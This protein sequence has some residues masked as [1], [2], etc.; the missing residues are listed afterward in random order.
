MFMPDDVYLTNKTARALYGAVRGLPIYDY[1]SHLSAQDM[2]DD[3]RYDNIGRL[4][5]ERRAGG[6]DHGESL[7]AR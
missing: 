1:H 7:L 4:W 6:A 5:L 3:R 2:L